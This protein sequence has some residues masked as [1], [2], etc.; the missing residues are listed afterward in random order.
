MTGTGGGV[1]T[2]I[3][4]AYTKVVLT[5]F[6]MTITVDHSLVFATRFETVI[7]RHIC[8]HFDFIK[9]HIRPTIG[10]TALGYR[11]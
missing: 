6:S 5:L 3:V 1:E 7:R 10:H 11:R 4:G 8:R 9:M 2:T